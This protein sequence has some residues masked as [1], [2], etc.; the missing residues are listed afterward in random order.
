[1]SDVVRKPESHDGRDFVLV[2][3]AWHGGWV[4]SRV[5]DRLRRFGH[6]VFTPTLTGMGE[7]SHIRHPGI[8]CSVHV[9]DVMNLIK[10]ERLRDVILCG[11]S[12]G[13]G[14]AGA[15]A[16]AIPDRIASIIYLD[17]AVPRNGQSIFDR[18][19]A[20]QL[21]HFA[22][23]ASDH[24]GLW[25]PPLPAA[26]FNI[27][28]NADQ[29]MVNALCT[30]QPLA[31]LLQRLTLT[32]AYMKIP[33]KAYI[34]ALQFN[35]LKHELDEIR[36]DKSWKIHDVDCGHHVMLDEPDRLAEILIASG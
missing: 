23:V 4:F 13:A 36:K 5:A 27:R 26:A 32:G 35:L 33:K 34:R 14:I 30:P 24:G 1:M 7:R 3:G 18:V 11:W 15:V 22:L 2:H 10:W 21:R 8:N 9:E 25:I 20:D 28:S 17:G 6:R 31:T 16:D 12:Y 29:D 19:D